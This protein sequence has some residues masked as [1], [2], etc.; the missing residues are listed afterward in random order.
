MFTYQIKIEIKP[1]KKDEFK[2]T[3]RLFARKILKEKDCLG[4]SIYH[5]LENE[6]QY[7][8]VGEWK[9]GQAMK[10]HFRTQDFEVFFGVSKVLGKNFAMNIAEVSKKGS[11]KLA[12][13]L[14]ASQISISQATV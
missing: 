9:T 1:Y 2:K 8:V 12:R 14:M 5:D 10:D 4:Y 7:V 13:E 6:N 11:F 3:M